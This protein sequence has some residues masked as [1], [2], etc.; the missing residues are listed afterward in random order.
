MATLGADGR[1][2]LKTITIGEDDGDT[3]KISAGLAATD[4]VIDNP[5]DALQTGD[6][7]RIAPSG[8]DHAQG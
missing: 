4:R 3:V 5:P 1:A 7:V 2:M 8:N 6:L